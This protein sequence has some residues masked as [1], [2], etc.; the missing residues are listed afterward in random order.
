MCEAIK[1]QRCAYVV[2]AAWESKRREKVSPCN[3]R[4]DVDEAYHQRRV[5]SVILWPVLLRLTAFA[6]T[7]IWTALPAIRF[8]CFIVAPHLRSTARHKRTKVPADRDARALIDS[9]QTRGRWERRRWI[10]P[11]QSSVAM[12]SR[13]QLVGNNPQKQTNQQTNK[14]TLTQAHMQLNTC[15]GYFH[16]SWND[17]NVILLHVLA[18]PDKL[19]AVVKWDMFS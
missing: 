1:M 17:C 2:G 11:V 14:K 16:K 18:T 8:L 3:R 12:I 6:L 5:V 15:K 7:N 13:I 9:D 19:T 10:F 4:R